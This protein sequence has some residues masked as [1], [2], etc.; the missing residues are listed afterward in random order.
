M[1]DRKSYLYRI[2]YYVTGCVWKIGIEH[3]TTVRAPTAR[4]ARRR[5]AMPGREILGAK[6]VRA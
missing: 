2:R 6:R 1:T 4:V 3:T 5:A